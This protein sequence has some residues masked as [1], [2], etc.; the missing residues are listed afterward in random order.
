M[1]K[2]YMKG[3]KITLSPNLIIIIKELKASL[4]LM[5]IIPFFVSLCF[6]SKGNN[7]SLFSGQTRKTSLQLLILDS[8][9]SKRFVLDRY[10]GANT[11]L[12]NQL[13][14]AKEIRILVY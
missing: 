1:P 9:L 10:Y 13:H 7:Y 2:Y 14:I 6:K 8:S 12:I 11:Y 5:L 4:R 3:I